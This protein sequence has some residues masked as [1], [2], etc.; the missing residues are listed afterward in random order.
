MDNQNTFGSES[1]KVFAGVLILVLMDNQNT[2]D[3]VFSKGGAEV[4]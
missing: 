3:D 1:V 4:S 2:E